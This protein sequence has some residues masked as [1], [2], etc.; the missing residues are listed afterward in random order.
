MK[1][2]AL[3]VMG[4]IVVN[5]LGCGTSFENQSR[6][7]ASSTNAKEH[8]ESLAKQ[9][10]EGMT[11]PEMMKLEYIG[12][13][14]E[15]GVR[16]VKQ[17]EFARPLMLQLVAYGK[18]AEEPLWTLIN[19]EDESVRRSCVML[20]NIRAEYPLYDGPKIESQAI[21]ELC[22]PILERVLTSKDTEVQFNACGN[23]A[24]YKDF[25]DD[26]LDRLRLTLPMIREL[27]DD[28]NDPLRRMAWTAYNSILASL[29]TRGKT[30][31]IRSQASE[32]YKAFR[33]EKNW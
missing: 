4:F 12:E 19:D 2:A 33:Q 14:A 31:E 10:R 17:R 27:K 1:Y 23:L 30:P 7:Q 11:K 6:P 26:C 22:I 16:G 18:A 28:E 5:L 3:C 13:H 9:I 32:E 21:Q 29:T 20:L 8:T 24:D 15:L 25:S